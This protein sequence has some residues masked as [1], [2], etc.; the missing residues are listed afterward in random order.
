MK[1][2]IER[3]K[4]KTIKILQTVKEEKEV[5][6]REEAIKENCHCCFLGEHTFQT[7][8]SLKNLVNII[9][10][11]EKNFKKDSIIVEYDPYEKLYK[12][13]GIEEKERN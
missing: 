2:N 9:E 12:I 7:F 1:K 5:K 10:K 6:K 13:H 8:E 3:L 4:L 11:Q